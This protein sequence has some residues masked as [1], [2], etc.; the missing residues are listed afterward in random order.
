MLAA[1]RIS[2]LEGT[3]HAREKKRCERASASAEAITEHGAAIISSLGA[4]D[5]SDSTKGML[6][7]KPRADHL[8]AVMGTRSML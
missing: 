2:W 8:N 7:H 6:R 1:E 3:A 5:W 4:F